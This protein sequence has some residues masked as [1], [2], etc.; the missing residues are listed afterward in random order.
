MGVQIRPL[1]CRIMKAILSVVI[2][3]AAM[4]KSPSFSREVLSRTMINSPRP[5]PGVI[6]RGEVDSSVCGLTECI[7]GTFDGVGVQL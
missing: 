1:V 2:S 4:I 7:N 6:S 3:D 5:D